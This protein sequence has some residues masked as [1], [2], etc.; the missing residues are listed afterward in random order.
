MTI[1]DYYVSWKSSLT[2]VETELENVERIIVKKGADAKANIAEVTIYNNEIGDGRYKYTGTDGSLS[3]NEDD[4]IK[5][6]IQNTSTDSSL[7]ITDSSPS[8]VGV[9]DLVEFATK[10]DDKAYPI[11]LKCVDKTYNLLNKLSVISIPA[12]G[13]NTSATLFRERIYATPP[14]LIQYLIQRVCKQDYGYGYDVD[15]NY[16]NSGLRYGIDARLMVT[17]STYAQQEALD[18]AAT[19]S[20]TTPAYIQ[21]QRPNSGGSFFQTGLYRGLG[22]SYKPTY[23]VINELSTM[24]NT[25]T[26][27][28]LTDGT[29][30]CGRTYLYHVDQHN[31]FHWFYPTDNIDYTFDQS[32]VNTTPIVL[33]TNL[34]KSTFDMVNMVIYNTGPDFYGAGTLWYAI[35]PSSK[36]KKLAMKYKPM[37]DESTR[38]IQAERVAGNITETSSG[39]FNWQGKL[40][41]RNGSVVSKFDNQTY[42]TDTDYNNGLRAYLRNKGDTRAQ[43]ILKK[44]GSPRWKGTI[45]LE[46]DYYTANELLNFTAPQTGQKE[47]LFRIKT[48]TH[49]VDKYGWK[50]SLDVEEDEE[51]SGG[52]S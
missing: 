38:A 43:T 26:D 48:V 1:P 25:N 4:T 27:T 2:G 39:S 6:F 45:E 3:F 5:V 36:S 14:R 40:Y 16:V 11:T 41:N 37:L 23:E 17:S 22:K 10:M 13:T 12:S 18:V 52:F 51:E 49:T 31:R 30:P 15:G 42:T 34:A 47:V 9:F 28:E 35:D 24:N 44:H 32:V 7:D 8:L 19:G 20:A 33:S 21:S 50:T 29:E 46:G